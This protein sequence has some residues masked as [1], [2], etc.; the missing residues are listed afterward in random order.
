MNIGI[1]VG[2]QSGIGLEII[3]KSIPLFPDVYFNIIGKIIPKQLITYGQVSSV[4]GR[5]A[6]EAIKEAID[7]AKKGVIDAIVTA[8][9][10][11]EA[12]NRGGWNYAGHTEM[13]ADLTN[14]P[15]Y[16]MMLIH[17][18]LKVI[19]VTTHCS[20]REA[21]DLITEKRIYKTI[22]IADDACKQLGVEAPRIGVAGLNPHCGEG[23]MFGREELTEII[24]AINDTKVDGIDVA[25]FPIP[26]DVVFAKALG[27]YYDCV[28]VMYHD[29]GHI[30]VKTVGFKWQGNEWE[31]IDG[32]N[33]TF[34]LPIIRTSP[35][36]GVAFG[37]AGKGIA[38]PTSMISAIKI[39]IK[40]V[41]GRDAKSV[42]EKT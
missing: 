9:I 41:E 19:H 10:C 31:S 37:K 17:K 28:V 16:A 23:G 3:E 27:G 13:F 29:Q 20:L 32:V 5:I 40:L 22:K 11:K 6:G 12:F 15:D 26:A 42:G 14:S 38:D 2:D 30:P 34:G 4:C 35:D 36:H 39:A 1:T 25:D 7:L 8:P 21:L 33:V 18:N 24:P